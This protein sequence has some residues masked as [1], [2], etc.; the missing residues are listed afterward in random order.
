M[1]KKGLTFGFI[2]VLVS[3]LHLHAQYAKQDGTYKKWYIG[4]SLL[5]MVCPRTMLEA[6]L[7]Q[8][9]DNQSLLVFLIP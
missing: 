4:S 7:F 5:L 8:N 3:S 9:F 6:H 2:L 1:Q